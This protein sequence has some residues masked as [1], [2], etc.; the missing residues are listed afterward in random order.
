VA[1][2]VEILPAALRELDRL[3]PAVRQRLI[4]RLDALALQPR[5]SGIKRVV[6]A[7]GVYR[8]RVGEY[9]A[10]Y[11]IDDPSRRVIVERVGH[12]KDVY[13]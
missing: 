1:Y 5:P 2:A 4:Q 6:G 13:R 10:I 9:R 7:P 12:R 8:I 3:P 11:R